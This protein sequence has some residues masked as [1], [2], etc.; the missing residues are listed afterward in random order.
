MIWSTGA[1]AWPGASAIVGVDIEETCYCCLYKR[2]MTPCPCFCSRQ[3]F[4][5]Y[6]GHWR[7]KK[8]EWVTRAQWIQDLLMFPVSKRSGG[9]PASSRSLPA[10][11]CCGLTWLFAPNRLPRPRSIRLRLRVLCPRSAVD[12]SSSDDGRILASAVE[13]VSLGR[14]LEADKRRCF[15]PEDE[16]FGAG[17]AAIPSAWDKLL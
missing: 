2:T 8:T 14:R 6:C 12:D 9:G 5:D 11:F 13:V 15:F 17:D 1:I 4:S 7:P 16:R 10:P 3:G